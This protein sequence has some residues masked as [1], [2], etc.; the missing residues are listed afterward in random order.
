[1]IALYFIKNG[2]GCFTHRGRAN[3]PTLCRR[4]L[5]MHFLQWEYMAVKSLTWWHHQMETF[6]ALLSLCAGNSPV[7]GE[8]PSQRPVTQTSMFS[9]ICAWTNANNRDAGDLRRHR[10]HYDVIVMQ[11]VNLD[12]KHNST[13][14]IWRTMCLTNPIYRIV[15]CV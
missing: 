4:K 11:I 14:G 8:F 5:Q 6:F 7:T 13:S 1:M 3:W 15:Y 10:A 12:D 9:L 2:Q